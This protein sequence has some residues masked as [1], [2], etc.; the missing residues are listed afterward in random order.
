VTLYEDATR[1]WGL[2]EGDALRVLTALPTSSIDAVCVDPP[3]GI[4]FHNE[5]WDGAD[6]HRAVAGGER[7]SASEAFERWTTL[8]AS[9]CRRVLKP[10]G[11]LL[12]FSA[13]RTFPRLVCGVEDAGLEVR[14]QLLW[15][16]AQGLPKSR[17]LPGGLGTT[18]KPAFE[19]ILLA[20]K[21]MEGRVADNLEAFGTGALNIDAAS[22]A[23]SETATGYWP[24]N[25]ALSH[26]PT[27]SD[28]SCATACPVGLLP[29]PHSRLC[30]C[31]KA[32]RRERE[33][34]CEM[35]PQRSVQVYTGKHHPPRMV[36]NTH[37]T[38][39]PLELMRWLVRLVTPPGGLVLDP[40]TG[41]G[42]TGAAAVLEQRLFLGIE[43][44]P[45][46]VDIAC[47][48]LTHWAREAARESA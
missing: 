25:V 14:D 24:A 37:P 9:E 21:P 45:E 47:A 12:A 10:G 41:S 44:E 23:G 36:H 17:R 8:W 3:Y 46:Y 27:C 6:I 43:R 33:A 16:H 20:R 40:F 32:T 29:E 22:I 35:L 39:K 13:A 38:V 28:G 31:A 19:P 42:S 30:F 11:H 48:R 4:G 15:L 7:L 1:A 2:I 5:A 26:A 18:L 34:G